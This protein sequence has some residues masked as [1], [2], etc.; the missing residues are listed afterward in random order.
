MCIL[1]NE[2]KPIPNT[3]GVELTENQSYPHGFSFFNPAS[4]GGKRYFDKSQT[5]SALQSKPNQRLSVVNIS[6]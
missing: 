5:N 4:L 6:A 2:I 1:S 3:E